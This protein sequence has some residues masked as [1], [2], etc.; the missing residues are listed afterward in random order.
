[1]LGGANLCGT[2]GDKGR[3]ESIRSWHARD[4]GNL[5]LITVLSESKEAGSVRDT[6]FVVNGG[7]DHLLHVVEGSRSKELVAVGS[8]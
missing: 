5:E 3:E 4:L 1:M 6:G 7:K 2:T 8:V